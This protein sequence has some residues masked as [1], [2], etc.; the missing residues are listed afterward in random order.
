MS[1]LAKIYQFDYVLNFEEVE[2]ME[3]I[4]IAELKKSELDDMKAFE[5]NGYIILKTKEGKTFILIEKED[6]IR[7]MAAQGEALPQI[8][9]GLLP[10]E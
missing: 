9:I 6:I 4:S 10:S 2:K 5:K 3:K 1:P 8:I 7:N